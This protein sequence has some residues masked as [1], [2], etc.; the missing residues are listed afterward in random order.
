MKREE[1]ELITFLSELVFDD[2]PNEVIEEAGLRLLDQAG[3]ILAG[4]AELP[5]HHATEYA[6]RRGGVPE[7]HLFGSSRLIDAEH[8]AFAN[9]ISGHVLELDDGNRF[10]MGHPAVVVIPAV[11]ALGEALRANGR[12]VVTAIVVGY[13]MFVRLGTAINPSHYNRGFHTTGTVGTLAATA[14]A[15]RLMGLN[16]ATLASALGLAGSQAGGLFEFLEDGAMS[17]Q[18]HAG[19]AAAAAIRSVRLAQAGFTGPTTVLQG[20]NG[21]MRAMADESDASVLNA[22]LGDTWAIRN[23][24]VK[25]HACCRHIHP[26]VDAVDEIVQGHGLTPG[27]VRRVR[28]GTYAFG[29]KLNNREIDTDLDAKMSTPYSVAATLIEGE[30]GLAQFR[31]ELYKDA[32]V[33]ALMERVEVVLDADLEVLVPNKRGCRV[34]I[35]TED[36]RFDSEVLLPR[37]EPET[38][39]GREEIERKYYNLVRDR[40]PKAAATKYAE[41][42][43]SIAD[44]KDISALNAVLRS[45][46]EMSTS[47]MNL[48]VTP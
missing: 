28:V 23:C 33:G 40:L 20:T 29:A 16:P 6:E 37:G 43:L 34:T 27:D 36:E 18:L 15:A 21:F 41:A 19:I 25:L 10:A 2:L 44:I 48:E 45:G 8:A 4:T 17:K 12:D 39:V 46:T 42:A 14:A 9:G 31:P 47:R 38:R 13:E 24:Y 7:A 22:G 35:E 3:V 5:A 26:V 1:S 30:C 32:H 11:L